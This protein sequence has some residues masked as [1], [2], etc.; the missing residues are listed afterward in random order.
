VCG[1]IGA[2]GTIFHS[3]QRGMAPGA[4]IHSYKVFP[5]NDTFTLGSAIEAGIDHGMDVI[6][7][8]LSSPPSKNITQK[9]P[10]CGPGHQRG[11]T[12]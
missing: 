3:P 1:V 11:R 4:E 7:I 8:R 5:G 6:N 9:M 10:E 2:K 12:P